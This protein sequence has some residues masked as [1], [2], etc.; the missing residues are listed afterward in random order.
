MKQFITA[1][2]IACLLCSCAPRTATPQDTG[3][4]LEQSAMP[5]QLAVSSAPSAAMPDETLLAQTPETDWIEA[6]SP[7]GAVQTR[8]RLRE[9]SERPFAVSSVVW[10]EEKEQFAAIYNC[11]AYRGE[12]P[13]QTY[14]EDAWVEVQTFDRNGTPLRRIRTDVLPMTDSMEGEV[15]DYAPCAYQGDWISFHAGDL[16]PAYIFINDETGEVRS[17]PAQRVCMDGAFF[18]L[19]DYEP[20]RAV[21]LVREGEVLKTVLLPELGTG[22]GMRL[23]NVARDGGDPIAFMLDAQAQ[24]ASIDAETTSVLIDFEAGS[25]SLKRQYTHDRLEEQLA[26]SADGQKILWSAQTGGA[27]DGFWS[28]L[29][30]EDAA[31]GTLTYLS[32]EDGLAIPEFGPGHLFLVNRLGSMTVYDADTAAPAAEQLAFDYG[33]TPNE[34]DWFT[35][36][37]SWDT[38]N[39]RWIV[40]Y[41]VGGWGESGSFDEQTPLLIDVFDA[42]GQKQRTVETGMEIPFSHKN[43]AVMVQLFPEGDGVRIYEPVS[44]LSSVVALELQE[45]AS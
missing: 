41:R 39:Q 40:A 30:L 31:T 36:G 29:V 14:R 13:W 32:D 18:A 2:L 43:Y 45:G 25:A 19:Y 21:R 35:L 23:D 9:P 34:P 26:Q 3:T 22:L 16:W 33:D 8:L 20:E 17:E 24:T 38:D 15:L 42:Q 11:S 44:G 37:C 27:G 28:E 5:D 7:D 6:V 10:N 1:M 4:G 12:Y